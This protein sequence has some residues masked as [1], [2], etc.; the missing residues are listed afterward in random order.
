MDQFEEDVSE[1]L[2]DRTVERKFK[3]DGTEID[4]SIPFDEQTAQM[5]QTIVEKASDVLG[6]DAASYRLYRGLKTAFTVVDPTCGCRYRDDI[7]DIGQILY[8][9]EHLPILHIWL[10][11]YDAKKQ[12]SRSATR[13]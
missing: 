13:V 10:D 2:I 5:K 4:F 11:S 12:I 8:N 7:C 3:V 9:R 1:I 6:K